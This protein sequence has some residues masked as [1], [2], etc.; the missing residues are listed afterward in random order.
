MA[1]ITTYKINAFNG[2]YWNYIVPTGLSSLFS[3]I[4]IEYHIDGRRVFSDCI[5]QKC[6]EKIKH[7][8]LQITKLINDST[9]CKC[10]QSIIDYLYSDEFNTVLSSIG[11]MGVKSYDLGKLVLEQGDPTLYEGYG[12]YKMNDKRYYI[13]RLSFSDWGYHDFNP[14]QIDISD[15]KTT[16]TITPNWGNRWCKPLLIYLR[17]YFLY[18]LYM[19]GNFNY[20]YLEKYGVIQLL[21]FCKEHNLISIEKETA[22]LETNVFDYYKKKYKIL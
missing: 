1:E 19:N 5:N 14:P 18:K 21:R 12:R 3:D 8:T 2:A 22:P 9:N 13:R 10:E 20:G 4:K 16:Q 15:N 7:I 11:Y 17:M 6:S